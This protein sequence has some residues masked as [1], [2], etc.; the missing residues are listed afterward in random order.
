[1]MWPALFSE[2]LQIQQLPY[3]RGVWG[4]VHGASS[5]FRWIAQSDQFDWQNNQLERQLNLGSED[6]PR[7]AVFWRSLPN[8]YYAV[9]SYPSRAQDAAGRSGFLEKQV[10]EWNKE[11]SPN[12]PAV[13]LAFLLLSQ[14]QKFDDTVWWNSRTNS[15]WAQS[16]FSLPIASDDCVPVPYSDTLLSEAIEIGINHL[17]TF[18]KEAALVL[19][20]Q[21]L[22]S[23]QGP[24]YLTGVQTPFS[25]EALATL[26]LPLKR[27][28]AD[29]LSLA[30]WVPSSRF[31]K[32]GERWDCIILPN[33]DRLPDKAPAIV[34]HEI[35]KQAKRMVQALFANDPSLLIEPETL[36]KSS[37]DDSSTAIELDLPK[38][39]LNLEDIDLAPSA[40]APEYLH[41][42][43]RFAQA[44]ERR[45]LAPEYLRRFCSNQPFQ[46]LEQEAEKIYDW[47][48]WTAAN[49]PD[50]A[51]EEQWQVK[52]DLLKALA[53]VLVPRSKALEEIRL[54]E[55]LRVS[56]LLFADLLENST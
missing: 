20:Y 33:H 26:L 50:Y 25:P 8:R 49:K 34:D 24:V 38:T 44:N 27:E 3:R 6:K 43:Y 35:E 11:Q 48:K 41:E 39:K 51:D 29:N 45:W 18:V 1:M 4:K 23:G 40:N 55:G 5:D 7:T 16:D 47:I 28:Q 2:P 19:F 31:D 22:L 21:Q 9:A 13:V 12:I 52:I 56:A 53:L 10:I 30:G 32:I 36:D 15:Q 54:S 46:P 17:K 42:I 14:A 37:S